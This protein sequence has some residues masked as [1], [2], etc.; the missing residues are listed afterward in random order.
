MRCVRLRRYKSQPIIVANIPTPATGP[1]T[2][3]ATHAWL[4]WDAAGAGE[5]LVDWLVFVV[6]EV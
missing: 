6:R 5:E 3:P 1:M 2:A 4:A